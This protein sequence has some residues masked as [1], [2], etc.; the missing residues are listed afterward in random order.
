MRNG[1]LVPV[2]YAKRIDEFE[3]AFNEDVASALREA[4][5]SLV[6]SHNRFGYSHGIRWRIRS[7]QE[8]DP[9]G[10]LQARSVE[11]QFSIDAILGNELSALPEYQEK[12]VERMMADFMRMMYETVNGATEKTGNV[13]S[14]GGGPFRAEHFLEMLEKVELGVDRHGRVTLPAIHAGPGL[15]EKIFEE[16]SAQGPEFERRV[17]EIKTRKTQ[18][19]L[20][21]E[22]MRRAKFRI[23]QAE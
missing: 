1:R 10:E 9:D 8:D 15:A 18:E 14:A 5:T 23:G 6:P 7:D 21:K 3:K 4:Q 12:I 19:A 11:V 22:A 17:D 20:S 13:I 16:L 2:Q